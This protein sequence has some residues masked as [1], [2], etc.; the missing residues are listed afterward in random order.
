L[1]VRGPLDEPEFDQP[2]DDAGCAGRGD[3]LAAGKLGQ[4]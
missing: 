1:G 2:L 3:G 4:V